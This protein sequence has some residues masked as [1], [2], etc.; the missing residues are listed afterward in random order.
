MP[1]NGVRSS[2]LMLD[3]NSLLA[4]L[5]ASAFSLAR[6]RS[7]FVCASCSVRSVNCRVRSATCVSSR[8]L[9][10]RMLP[11]RHRMIEQLQIGEGHIRYIGPAGNLGG[12]KCGQAV[13]AD[14]ELLAA[15]RGTAG[16][17]PTGQ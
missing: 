17:E 3:R 1:F 9:R 16:G 12:E 8:R 4:W 5:A 2:W 7:W 15:G 14:I 6:A 10:A 13:V 11:S